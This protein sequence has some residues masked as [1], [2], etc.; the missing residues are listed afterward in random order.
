[1]EISTTNYE[2]FFNIMTKWKEISNEKCD[3]HLPH[4][5]TFLNC[6]IEITQDGYDIT[7]GTFEPEENGN[8]N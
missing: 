1:M 5:G 7:Y 8:G 4:C 3:I 2:K 6:D